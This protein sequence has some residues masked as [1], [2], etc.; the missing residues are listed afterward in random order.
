MEVRW[1]EKRERD[2]EGD[3]IIIRTN[4][5]YRA[6]NDTFSVNYWSEVLTSSLDKISVV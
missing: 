4:P 2:V 6:T 5:L 3:G 1:Q